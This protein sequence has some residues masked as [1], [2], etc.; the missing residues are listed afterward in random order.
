MKNGLIFLTAMTLAGALVTT[1]LAQ[2]TDIFKV[3][4]ENGNVTFTD[5]PPKDG[6]APM[7]L[8]EITVIE[9]DYPNLNKPKDEEEVAGDQ[10]LSLADL[11]RMYRDFTIY[12]P[13]N[14]ETFSGTANTVVIRWG[15]QTPFEPGLNTVLTVNGET[16]QVAPQ[17]S[18]S[19][20]LDR[21]EHNVQATL[22]DEGGRV[23]ANA[24]PVTFF[25]RQ[26]SVGFNRAPGVRPN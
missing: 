20:T 24:G 14:E 21:G 11:R 17:G 19:L 10:P 23:V 2:D 26:S 5:T 18:V 8:P 7:D 25:V 13:A 9:V 15:S 1:V 4:D 12:S 6:S 16:T 22:R 3:V